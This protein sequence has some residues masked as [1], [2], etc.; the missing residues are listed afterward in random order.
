MEAAELDAFDLSRLTDF[1]F[2]EVCKDLFENILRVRLEI[3]SAGR[4]DGVDLRYT[5]PDDSASTTVIQ[6]KHWINSPSSQLIRHMERVELPKIQKLQ[7]D[8]YVLVSSTKLT[9]LAKDK[10]FTLLSPYVRSPQDIYGQDD[11][12]GELRKQPDIVKR[13][14]RLWL[15]SSAVLDTLLNRDIFERSLSLADE[16]EATARIFVPNRSFGRAQDLLEQKHVCLIS[17]APGIGKT[18]LARVLA[19]AYAANG[20]EL[21][22]ISEDANEANRVWNSEKPQ[23][24]YYDDFLGQTSLDEKLNKNEDDRLLSLLRK[25]SNSPNKRLVLTTREYILNQAKQRYERLSRHNF[26]P[27]TCVVDLN[28]YTSIIRARI[29]YNHV[30]Y[31]RLT[32]EQ[33]REFA[34][35]DNYVRILQHRNFNPRLVALSLELGRWGHGSTACV[36]V[37]GNL[38]NPAELWQHIVDYDLTDAAVCLLEVMVSLGQVIAIEE[39]K[40]A[41]RRYCKRRDVECSDRAFRSSLETLENTLIVLNSYGPRSTLIILFHDPSVADYMQGRLGADVGALRDLVLSCERV[42]QLSQLLAV[43]DS[44]QV[45]GLR[46]AVQSCSDEVR[47]VLSNA[48]VNIEVKYVPMEFRRLGREQS[49]LRQL[50]SVLEIAVRF[51]FEDIADAS[52]AKLGPDWTYEALN[53]DDLIGFARVLNESSSLV[54]QP[55]ADA[56]FDEI[57][58]WITVDLSGWENLSSA[59]VQLDQLSQIGVTG[60]ANALERVVERRLE[61]AEWE[62]ERWHD[63]GDVSSPRMEYIA[64]VVD[65][66]S[67]WSHRDDITGYA[68][69]S[70]AVDDFRQAKW[71]SD[72][73][74]YEKHESGDDE[75][76]GDS[77]EEL[78][79]REIDELLALL[80]ESPN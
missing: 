53:P 12:I 39:L 76:S 7:P 35:P 16:L 50:T 66:V 34:D 47:S 11:V 23:F 67:S 17:G 64:S 40:E 31:S 1:D 48:L 2:E 13:H 5:T 79:R 18:T 68:Q 80:A 29:L 43:A 10:L 6:C 75:E 25:V 74:A 70:A 65:Y 33:R 44:S 54:P 60:A 19:A 59:E 77:N 28:D 72:R 46:E 55:R 73:D 22:E 69:A 58:E 62:L 21:I 51:S 37:L 15:A 61:D 78:M 42:A 36:S 3:F 63:D 4:D 38:D 8:R 26:D 32:V 20:F 30:F 56:I 71:D 45:L 41:W 14:L 27:T 49:W 24:Y 57:I 9:K 52:L